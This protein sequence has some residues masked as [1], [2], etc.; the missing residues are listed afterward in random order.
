M[1][2][3]EGCVLENSGDIVENLELKKHTAIVHCSNSLSLLQRKLSNALLY[4]AY[5]SLLDEE[6]HAIS[7][8]SLCSLIS[9]RG[10]NYFAIKEAL[11]GLI[12]T[13]IEWNLIDTQTLEEDW[14]ASSI[15][16]SINLKN[17][18]CTYAY[19][20]RMKKLLYSPSMF[21]KINLF[22]QAHFK[23]SYGLALYENCVRYQDI[24]YTKWFELNLFRKLMGVPADTYGL[25]KDFKRRVLDK[26][27]EEVNAFSELFIESVFQKK[28]RQ[29]LKVRFIIKKRTRKKRIGKQI[30]PHERDTNLQEITQLKQILEDK[31]DLSSA[32]IAKI[33]DQY[34]LDYI[35]AKITLIE[36]S[37][38]FQSGRINNSA[39]LL[40]DALKN[41]YNPKIVNTNKS[42]L[43]GNKQKIN[44]YNEQ[45]DSRNNSKN[46]VEVGVPATKKSTKD[47]TNNRDVQ[48]KIL[49]EMFLNKE[50]PNDKIVLRD[51]EIYLK[52]SLYYEIYLREGFD[53]ILVRDQFYEYIIKNHPKLLQFKPA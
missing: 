7:I 19:S 49:M 53:N 45:N 25:F 17:G 9:Y 6:E 24:G 48:S 18:I 3:A 4:H 40:M 43:K 34:S 1:E 41:D 31:F 22:V 44:Y 28:G 52:T 20:P 35:Q 8:A 12:T 16:A 23:S 42:N 51:F 47:S 33:F 13:S 10:H 11:R 50:I 27:M 21:A 5:K 2:H 36:N 26:A 38:S 39:G 37:K 29:V 30:I 15:L 46:L 14:T 32:M